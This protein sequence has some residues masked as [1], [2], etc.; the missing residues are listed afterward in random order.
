MARVKLWAQAKSGGNSGSVSDRNRESER[1][2]YLTLAA[3]TR[4]RVEAAMQVERPPARE[5][6][7][8]FRFR[9]AVH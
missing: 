9:A 5:R 8:L 2:F 6:T 3:R 4:R 1:I 7:P